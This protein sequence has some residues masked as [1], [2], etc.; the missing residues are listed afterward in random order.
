M[1]LMKRYGLSARRSIGQ[2]TIINDRILEDIVAA[3]DL[4]P[5][6]TVVEVGAGIGNLTTRLAEKAGRVMAIELDETFRP[7]HEKMAAAYPDLSFH[8]AD[9]VKWDWEG[10]VRPARPG[11][12]AIAGNI[13]Y[14]IT[15]PLVIR[16]L[17]SPLEWR[18]T[19]FMTQREVAERLCAKPGS[20]PCGSV[21][22]KTAL[23]CNT[24]ILFAVGADNFHPRPRVESAVIR[25]V[26]RAEPLLPGNDARGRFFK[27]ADALFAHRRKQAPNS[28]AQAGA[29]GL[30]QAQ[31]KE[32]MSACG[33]VSSRR[34]ESLSLEESLEL[35]RAAEAARPVSDP[36]KAPKRVDSL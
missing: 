15:T 24:E 34:G 35:F 29:F 11:D 26:R 25:L 31:W 1:S 13:P 2:H 5:A 27:F 22:L 8:Y 7:L 28:L 9:A 4:T 36:K 21:S 23:M 19:V 20:K 14:Q 30:S 12:L 33:L 16:L 32:T 3:C 17:A 18:A 10:N 6:T